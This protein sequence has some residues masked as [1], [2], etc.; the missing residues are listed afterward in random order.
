[1][2]HPINFLFIHR[3]QPAP[4]NNIPPK[5]LQPQNT[6]K[7]TLAGTSATTKWFLSW[8][9]K[10]ISPSMLEVP[11]DKSF[12]RQGKKFPANQGNWSSRRQMRD[13]H[14]VWLHAC[15]TTKTFQKAAR[16]VG[17]PEI[18]YDYSFNRQI[19]GR[20]LSDD[21]PSPPVK[22]SQETAQVQS[23]EASMTT[24]LADGL[25]AF[26]W[27]DSWHHPVQACSSPRL[28]P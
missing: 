9:E 23:P 10:K 1:M 24:V 2:P 12:S 26:I 20:H 15:S 13:R 27:S 6:L 11:L 8:G 18:H 25:K 4:L 16:D 17:N 22:I 14:L 21:R 5:K 7:A 28:S 3:I 19:R